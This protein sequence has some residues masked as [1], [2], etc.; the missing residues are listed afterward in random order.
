MLFLRPQK[1]LY[2]THCQEV[3]RSPYTR[4]CSR[5]G[6]ICLH[7]HQRATSSRFTS[8]LLLLDVGCSHCFISFICF[9]LFILPPQCPTYYQLHEYPIQLLASLFLTFSSLS[10]RRICVR[11]CEKN[12]STLEAAVYK[13]QS[14]Y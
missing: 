6:D 2:L 5:T 9:L 13:T 11:L 1:S 4:T 10:Y 8:T 7:S 3:Y 12:T 14:T